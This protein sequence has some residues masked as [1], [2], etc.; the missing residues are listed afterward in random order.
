MEYRHNGLTKSETFGNTNNYILMP[1]RN[2][3]LYKYLVVYKFVNKQETI[4]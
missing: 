1:N 2:K 4:R 3:G